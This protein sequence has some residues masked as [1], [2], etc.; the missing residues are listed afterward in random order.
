L[1]DV[2]NEAVAEIESS[3]TA[4]LSAQ[5]IPAAPICDVSLPHNSMISD[6]EDY[7][8]QLSVAVYGYEQPC[9]VPN[10]LH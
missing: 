6:N 10:C 9:T 8:F 3:T 5:I 7:R 1:V 2:A 4:G